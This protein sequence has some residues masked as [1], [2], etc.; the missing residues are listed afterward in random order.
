MPVCEPRVAFMV[1]AHHEPAQFH[2]LVD[3]LT[4]E[5]AAVAAHIDAKADLRPFQRSDVAF[6]AD[7]VRVNWG[8]YSQVV[9]MQRVLSAALAAFPDATHFQWL[10][11][12]DYPVR[13]L[14]QFSRHLA[15]HSGVSF[16]AYEDMT[17]PGAQFPSI[18][19]EWFS[20]D[21]L[22]APGGRWL[23]RHEPRVSAL[24]RRL[25]PRTPPLGYTPF[26]GSA[27]S[28]LTREVAEFL[29]QELAAG[30]RRPLLCYFRSI[31]IPDEIAFQTV[32]CNSPLASKLAHWPQQPGPHALLHYIDW[33]PERENPAILDESDFEAVVQSGKW[34]VR[35]VTPERSH[36]LLGLLDSYAFDTRDSRGR[37]PHERS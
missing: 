4:A 14:S 34:F 21:L 16:M 18:P 29:L 8:G 12:L 30:T 33:S 22:A 23:A 15:D 35:K 27:W 9:C 25:P 2:R 36:R 24:L 1:M 31:R 11:G 3:R 37:P 5:G 17:A 20:H 26:R 13:P 7:R 32:L 6:A 10:S 28:C 19:Q